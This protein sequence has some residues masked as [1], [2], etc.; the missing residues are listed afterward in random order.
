MELPVKI[1]T[2]DEYNKLE[3]GIEYFPQ[4]HIAEI[5]QNSSPQIHQYLSKS[6]EYANFPMYPTY[7]SAPY[8]L[9][10]GE[11]HV[12]SDIQTPILVEPVIPQPVST[13][14]Y[15]IPKPMPVASLVKSAAPPTAQAEDKPA[16]PVNPQT[17]L[18]P[19][20]VSTIVCCCGSHA[21]CLD[22]N[23]SLFTGE[24]WRRRC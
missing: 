6:S 12:P 19:T 3:G 4:P 20:R 22:A 23:L 21:C 10:L 9:H 11:G 17:P 16:A 14:S 2:A 15:E 5:P 1:L 7:L 18:N 24:N 8:P 13:A